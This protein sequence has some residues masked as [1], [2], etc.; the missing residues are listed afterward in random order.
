MRRVRKRTGGINYDCS[1]VT[2]SSVVDNFFFISLFSF[3]E[4]VT[5]QNLLSFF[6]GER[7][8]WKTKEN[9]FAACK[10]FSDGQQQNSTNFVRRKE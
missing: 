8:W 1:I 4:C 3:I 7:R 2:V 5:F 6:Y 9:V 10:P